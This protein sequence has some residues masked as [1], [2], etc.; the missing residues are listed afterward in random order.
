MS[1]G[2]ASCQVHLPLSSIESDQIREIIRDLDPSDVSQSRGS[3]QTHQGVLRSMLIHRSEPSP[4][5]MLEQLFPNEI[6]RVIRR[7][8][9][10]E[11]GITIDRRERQIALSERKLEKKGI[12][13]A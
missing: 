4:I 1:I 9:M 11:Q 8:H 13:H 5:E 6:V 7:N 3:R 12:E 10:I 2:D